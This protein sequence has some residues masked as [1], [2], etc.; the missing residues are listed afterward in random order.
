MK[1]GMILLLSTLLSAS[2]LF[3]VSASRERT[4]VNF[5]NDVIN[6]EIYITKTY[7]LDEASRLAENDIFVDDGYT[8]SKKAT[9]LVEAGVLNVITVQQL[10]SRTYLNNGVLKEQYVT[11]S[12]GSLS[13]DDWDKSSS[14]HVYITT[15]FEK[16]YFNSFET[17]KIT[18]SVVRYGKSSSQVAV[19][20]MDVMAG[21]SGAGFDGNGNRKSVYENK[22]QSFTYPS[23][24]T[25]YTMSTGFQDYVFT[26]AATAGSHVTT[27]MRRGTATWS[28]VVTADIATV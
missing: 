11:R 24:V 23:S 16:T 6:Q 2:L 19:T 13:M 5:E 14:I 28:F 15:Y 9:T 25:D 7:S 10:Q 18:S 22:Q 1:K 21:Q 27:Y 17:V 12:A 26:S 4:E 3:Q 8:K 20:K